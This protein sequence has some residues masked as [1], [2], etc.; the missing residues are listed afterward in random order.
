MCCTRQ[1]N[2]YEKKGKRMLYFKLDS[3]YLGV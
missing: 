1:V 3:R 2:F